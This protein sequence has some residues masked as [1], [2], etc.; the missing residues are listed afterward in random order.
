[1]K[2]SLVIPTYNEKEN[3]EKLISLL[4][5]NFLKNKIDA[6]IIVVDDN[7]PDGTGDILDGLVSKYP[8]LRVVHRSGKLGLSSAALDGFRIARGELVG[9]MDAD[10]SHPIGKIKEMVQKIEEEGFDLVI[11]SRYVRGG[12]IDGWGLYRKILS[13]GATFLAR[14]FVDTIDPMTGFFITKKRLITYENLNPKGFKIL[15]ELLIK[16]KFEKIA[17]VPI[18]F[19]NRVVGKSKAGTKEI[20]F[21]LKNLVGYIPYRKETIIQFL[22][23]ALVGLF[24]TG[25][26]IFV[27]LIATEYF[28]IYYIVSSLLAFLVA[29]TGNFFLNKIWTFNEKVKSKILKK[30]FDF[31][32]VSTFAL[33]IN[34]VFLYVLTEFFG[35]H[36]LIS[37]FVSI[38]FGLVAN[39]AGN[40]IW[41]FSRSNYR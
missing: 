36:Y 29:M 27:L 4:T 41:T 21:F 24:G 8:S 19:T 14:I 15:L 18:I 5:D 26:N 6:E 17:E 11:G 25:I 23:F 30:Y 2:L 39:F 37:Q 10:L 34:I 3:I 13:R 7:S 1:M 16:I 12:R 31:F 9:L 32:L 40:K 22:K 38:G 20:I 28:G 35:I 33:F